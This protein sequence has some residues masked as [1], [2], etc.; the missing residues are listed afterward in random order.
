MNPDLARL[1]HDP[2]RLAMLH[3]LELLDPHPDPAF[4]RLT[5]LAA[6]IVQTPI[7]LVVLLDADRQVFKSQL[8][9]AE[10]WASRRATP[11]SHSF[12]QHTL[13]S[14]APLVVED[15]RQHPVFIT[16]AA[17]QDLGVVAYL[18]IPLLSGGQV[19][20]S[21][22]VID[23]QPRVWSARDIAIVQE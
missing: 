10:P 14:T 19:I 17:I 20:G 2:A 21:F 18:G 13:L 8:G 5:R 12:C 11:L 15:A 23:S 4:D 1:L 6:T 7:A 9:L 22:C 3:T 16:N